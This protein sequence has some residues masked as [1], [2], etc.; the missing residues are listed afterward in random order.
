MKRDIEQLVE[1]LAGEAGAVTPAPHPLRLS[2]AWIAAAAVYLAAALA[3]SGL[4]P[5]LMQK[6]HD[7][8]FAAEL[9]CLL[10]IFIATSVSAALLIFP[11]LH[12]KRALAWSP[13]WLFVVF[14][15]VL[16]LSCRADTPPAPLPVHSYQ[17]TVDI[18]LVM[19][20]PA[21]WTLYAMRNSASTHY[22]LAG[23][24]ALL[25]AFSVGSLWLRLHEANDSVLH[26]IQWHY[27]PMLGLG[28]IGLW[29]GRLL[30]KW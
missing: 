17:C 10:G 20:L 19:L 7:P 30:L 8:W 6:L 3:L 12:Q 2:L 28:L 4:R 13:A 26:V 27:L 24:I 25:S 15:V 18:A 29:L 5:D 11:D 16:Y 1:A 21:A 23:A 14:P 9:A 22:R